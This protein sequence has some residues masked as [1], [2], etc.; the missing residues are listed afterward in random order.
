[1]CHYRAADDFGYL[2]DEGVT[3]GLKPVFVQPRGNPIANSYISDT[4]LQGTP[5]IS[6]RVI[7]EGECR[8]CALKHTLDW[9]RSLWSRAAGV[10][11][12]PDSVSRV[13]G[14]QRR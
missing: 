8:D 10:G 6:K 1:M 12:N 14:H 9:L 11:H 3:E 13:R 4:A 7:I 5:R 2:W